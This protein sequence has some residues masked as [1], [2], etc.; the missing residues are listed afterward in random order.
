MFKVYMAMVFIF[1][2]LLEA[3]VIN[4]EYRGNSITYSKESYNMT[5]PDYWKKKENANKKVTQKSYKKSTKSKKVTKSKKSKRNVVG[6]EYRGNAISYSSENRMSR[7]EWEKKVKQQDRKNSKKMIN[8]E[9]QG[10][11]VKYNK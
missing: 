9:Y 2:G 4:D 11:S 8:D 7:A 10:N 1:V 6:D 5:N 3:K